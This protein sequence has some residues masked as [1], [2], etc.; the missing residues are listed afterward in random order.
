[1]PVTFTGNAMR[2]RLLV[3]GS[4]EQMISEIKRVLG[5][6]TSRMC[7]VVVRRQV[8]MILAGEKERKKVRHMHRLQLLC[9]HNALFKA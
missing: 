3:D 6:T 5:R 9:M 4:A 8:A 7:N 1:M 2:D